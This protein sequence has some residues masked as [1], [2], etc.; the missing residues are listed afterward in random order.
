M[1]LWVVEICSWGPISVAG[2]PHH[3]P[4][5]HQMMIMMAVVMIV[6]M[7][8]IVQYI[9]EAFIQGTTHKWNMCD[10]ISVAGACHHPP[11]GE[12]AESHDDDDDEA[13]RDF[14]KERTASDEKT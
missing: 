5:G 7:V 9:F 8:I 14:K 1:H 3:L 11:L 2:A 6:M 10:G 13:G 4:L 12:P